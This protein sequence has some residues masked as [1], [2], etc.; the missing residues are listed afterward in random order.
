M[1]GLNMKK[2]GSNLRSQAALEFLTT[3]AWAFLVIIIMVGA[4]A[5]FGVLSPTKLL[6]DRC[7]FG[8]EIGCNKDFMLIRDNITTVSRRIEN[9][10]GTNIIVT[11]ITPT[12]DLENLGV[13]NPFI[14]SVNVTKSPYTWNSDSTVELSLN[15]TNAPEVLVPKEKAKF[16]F[17]FEYYPPAAGPTYTKQTYGEILGTIQPGIELIPGEELQ[18]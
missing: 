9:N 14:D 17:E 11:K 12:S 13:C 16:Q 10:A 7:N 8:A 15:C 5:Y 4:L 2:R 18:P 3:Y 6:P 1:T